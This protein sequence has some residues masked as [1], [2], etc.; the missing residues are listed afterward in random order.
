M[1]AENAIATAWIGPSLTPL[2]FLN[3]GFRFY[4]VD[5]GSFDIM[6]AYTF[7]SNVTSNVALDTQNVVGPTF[8]LEYDTRGAYGGNIS[9]PASAPLNA[10]WWELVVQQFEREPALLEKF[11]AYQSKSSTQNW[12]CTSPGELETRSEDDCDAN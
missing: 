8:S 12:N 10:T 2:T 1:T 6:N 11:H 7:I 5:T 3:S 9:W 4:E